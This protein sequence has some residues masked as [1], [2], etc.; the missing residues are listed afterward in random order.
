MRTA[1]RW[2]GVCAV[3]GATSC[4][5]GNPPIVDAEVVLGYLPVSSANINV[6]A[7]PL[8][9]RRGQLY[10]ANVEPPAGKAGRNNLLTVIRQGRRNNDGSWSWKSHV[11]EP[12]TLD[13]KYH[14]QASIAVDRDG[15]VHVA[16][17]MHNMPWQY[18]ISKRPEDISEFVFHGDSLTQDQLDTVIFKNRVPYPSLGNAAIP[19]NQITYPAFFTDRH[20]DLYVTYR[21]ATR[22]RRAWK[23][24]GFAGAIAKYDTGTR[25]WTQ[26][27]GRMR[28]SAE[29][30]DLPRGQREAYTHPFAFED[31]W[32]VYLIRL[33][34]DRN[35]GMHASW[36]WRAGGAGPDVSHP[37]YAYSPDGGKSF[38]KANGGKYAL[39]V[40]VGQ[41]GHYVAEH[42][43]RRFHAPTAIAATD[44]GNPFII[45]IEMHK[46][47]R[48]TSYQPHSEEWS[49]PV[50]T[51]SGASETWID[52]DGTQWLFAGG[53]KV[54]RRK[55][56]IDRRWEV[57][58]VGG[59]LCAPRVVPV[60]QERSFF[61]QAR[62]CTKN[63]VT[64]V[65]VGMG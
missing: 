12:R 54:L 57:R 65:R 21:Y 2:V 52:D 63:S 11:L 20:G 26:I 30:A 45:F 3:I 60:P 25:T 18:A 62:D 13:D 56:G 43:G 28:V 16:Y 24:R 33:A 31:G 58:H 38:F 48:M 14:T 4:S 7:T 32:S 37:S 10:T 49:L 1:L 35:N 22:P 9:Y 61:I 15:Y 5:G 19:G 50:K 29:D 36:M 44:Q 59:N 64:I 34:F 51:P 6:F 47:W 39:P 55:P 27:G 23:E 8:A 53:L 41:A 46:P 17:N 42:E 40:R